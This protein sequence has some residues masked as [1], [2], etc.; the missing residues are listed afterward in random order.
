MRGLNGNVAAEPRLFAHDAATIVTGAINLDAAD[1]GYRLIAGGTGYGTNGTQ[2]G[3]VTG[4]NITFSASGTGI[5][6]TVTLDGG[7][8][9]N[10]VVTARGS[11]IKP[12][13][14]N[15]G[16]IGTIDA[17][18]GTKGDDAQILVTNFDIPFTEERGCV[19]YHNGS[20]A[21]S[22]KFMLESGKEITMRCPANSI[23]GGHVPL[24]IKQVVDADTSSNSNSNTATN[25][26]ALY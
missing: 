24:L 12:N 1:G 13:S 20:S 23:V 16:L 14:G 19:V 2:T 8:V 15:A 4:V 5:T 17:I 26:I 11:G 18:N 10:V 6:A 25:M 3:T 21:V 22:A 9:T 7:V